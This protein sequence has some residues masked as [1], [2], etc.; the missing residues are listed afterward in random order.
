[1][2]DPAFQL[3]LLLHNP[4]NSNEL[5]LLSLRDCLGKL[6]VGHPVRRWYNRRAIVRPDVAS[7][8]IMEALQGDLRDA[9]GSEKLKSKQREAIMKLLDQLDDYPPYLDVTLL[10]AVGYQRLGNWARAEHHLRSWL[11]LSPLERLEKTPARRDA[12]ASYMRE[13]LEVF[14]AALEKNGKD[15]FIIQV[16]LRALTETLTDG[17]VTDKLESHVELDEDEVLSKLALNY[18]RTQVPGF[19]DWYLNRQLER[20]RR[21]RFLDNFFASQDAVKHFWI[22]LGRMPDLPQHREALAKLLLDARKRHETI[23]YVMSTMEELRPFLQRLEPASLKNLRNERRQFFLSSFGANR[24]D[25]LSLYHLVEMGQVDQ[26]L[27]LS[28]AER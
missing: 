22:F 8:S 1:M 13:N 9:W 17:R 4:Q 11:L 19:S 21:E 10:Q 20:K 26:N 16:F 6:P 2:E 12:L 23:F 15:R 25:M 18:H 7:Q 24:N 14:L 3:A 28:V 5:F 27:V